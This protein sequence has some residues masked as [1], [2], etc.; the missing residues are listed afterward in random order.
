VIRY[1]LRV[2]ARQDLQEIGRY[3]LEAW[4]SAKR[5]AYLLAIDA[6]FKNLAAHPER[7]APRADIGPDW[8]SSRVGRHLIFYMQQSWGIEI[9]RVLH[10]SRDLVPTLSPDA[11]ED[12]NR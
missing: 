4:G 1:R 2:R 5:R 9:V 11:E 8:R 7:G 3:T 6:R 10:E 12:E